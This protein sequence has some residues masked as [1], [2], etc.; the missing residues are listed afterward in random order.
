MGASG[1]FEKDE[2]T[3]SGSD[4][5]ALV[6]NFKL[7]FL[8][9]I[10]RVRPYPAPQQSAGYVGLPEP[11]AWQQ[12]LQPEVQAQFFL[13]VSFSVYG[14]HLD[15]MMETLTHPL[16]SQSPL[17]DLDKKER[18]RGWKRRDVSKALYGSQ[19]ESGPR[20]WP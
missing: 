8:W 10:G 6:T 20:R 1:N 12:H 11:N 16:Q 3:I 18:T 19:C 17:G 9:S 4:N 5:S 7:A 2:V 15:S 13:R 14:H